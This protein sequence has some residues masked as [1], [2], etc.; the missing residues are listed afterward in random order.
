MRYAL[1]PGFQFRPEDLVPIPDGAPMPGDLTLLPD[2][3]APFEVTPSAVPS[4][5]HAAAKAPEGQGKLDLRAK[6]RRPWEDAHPQVN[7]P[8]NLRPR[9][10]LHAKLKWLAERMPATSMQK[11]AMQGIEREVERLLAIYDTPDRD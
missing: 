8:F 7:K 2:T 6:P 10:E 11:I 3:V 5:R 4:A 9:E 1:K